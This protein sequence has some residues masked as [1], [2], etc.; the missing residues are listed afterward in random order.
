MDVTTLPF[1]S[2]DSHAV[3]PRMLWWD[4][5]PESMRAAAPARIRPTEEGAWEMAKHEQTS[6]TQA[7]KDRAEE[8]ARVQTND[9]THRYQVMH[10][11]KIDAEI[12]FPTI[13]LYIWDLEDAELGMACCQIYND[14]IYDV[15]ESK[16]DRHRSAGLIPTWNIDHAI[17]EVKRIKA[18][19]MAS[20]ML[21]AHGVPYEYN[22]KY[23]EPLWDAIEES[24]LPISMHQGTGH[25]MLFYRG[26]GAAVSNLLAT[27]SHAPRTAG[28]LVDV[29]RART[30]PRPALRLRRDERGLDRLGD[31]H[32]RLLLR[33]VSGVPELGQADPEGEAELLPHPAGAWHVPVGPER[34]QQH[35]PYRRRDDDVGLGLSA[36]RGHVSAL[37]Q[38]CPGTLR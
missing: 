16:S 2:A 17:A 21:P 26:P 3:E 25:D 11:D 10:E 23:W 4:H 19:G 27:Q 12:V 30:P 7:Q 8:M 28:L 29:G 34:D 14:W 9:L 6:E 31:G 15:I 33:V 5:L 32:P 35:R 1:V 37:A 18:L 22:H 24:G 20:A 38:D 13:G 36:R